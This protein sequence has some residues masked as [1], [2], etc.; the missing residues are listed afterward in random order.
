MASSGSLWAPVPACLHTR[1][2]S[3]PSRAFPPHRD[4]GK[5]GRRTRRH[6]NLEAPGSRQARRHLSPRRGEAHVGA[7]RQGTRLGLHRCDQPSPA[8]DC[9]SAVPLCP[10]DALSPS[11]STASAPLLCHS[12]SEILIQASKSTHKRTKGKKNK[13]CASGVLSL[14]CIKHAVFRAEDRRRHTRHTV[15]LPCSLSWEAHVHAWRTVGLEQEAW[16]QA[17][18][19]H[20]TWLA[21]RLSDSAIEVKK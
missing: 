17:Q 12:N 9:F 19:P 5:H 6:L 8:G 18:P 4:S 15:P 1:V 3:S 10:H 11:P 20:G 14:V 13:V 2:G 16:P 21:P 7:G